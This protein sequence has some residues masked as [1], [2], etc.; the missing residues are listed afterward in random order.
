MNKELLKIRDLFFTGKSAFET[1]QLK[2]TLIQLNSYLEKITSNDLFKRQKNIASLLTD[3]FSS[4]FSG[5][6]A[7][8]L[9]VVLN[10]QTYYNF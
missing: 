5:N 8:F 6:L 1:E 2:K 7:S 10:K 3:I 9:A 4:A